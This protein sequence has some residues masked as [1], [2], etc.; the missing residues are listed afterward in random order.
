VINLYLNISDNTAPE[1]ATDLQTEFTM[2]ITQVNDYKLPAVTSD[3]V[4]TYEIYLNAMENQ[5]FPGFLSFNNATN[6]IQMRPK[7]DT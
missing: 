3:S 1:F 5:A 4:D 7:N 2:N 6:T